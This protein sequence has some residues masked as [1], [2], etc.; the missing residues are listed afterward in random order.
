MGTITRKLLDPGVVRNGT[1]VVTAK[2]VDRAYTEW[3]TREL[4]RMEK[5]RAYDLA[6]LAGLDASY[7]AQLQFNAANAAATEARADYFA[8]VSEAKTQ[9]R[10]RLSS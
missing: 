4:A 1:A 3:R 8:I 9:A 10:K 6:I 7:S 5:R 2:T